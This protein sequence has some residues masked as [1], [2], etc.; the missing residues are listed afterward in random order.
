M[1]EIR[2]AEVSEILKKEL[3]GLENASQ[4]EEV[5]V[6]LEVGDGIARIYGLN[7]VQSG[8]LIEFKNGSQ[9]IVLNLES[10]HV[11]AVLMDS[12]Q[13]I[14]QGDVVKRTKKIASIKVG[15]GMLG[16][17]VDCL[18]KPIDG[19]GSITGETYEMPL[20]RKAPGVLFR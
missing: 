15:K 1:S 18:G 5:G 6:V 16:R 13:S 14:K 11:G 7:D 12:S 19:K 4:F 20:E 17:V 2:P 3:A 8:E 10:D 9:G